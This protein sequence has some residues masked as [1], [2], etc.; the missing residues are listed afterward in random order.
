MNF[1]SFRFKYTPL[2]IMWVFYFLFVLVRYFILKGDIS[3]SYSYYLELEP[4]LGLF[5]SL[6]SFS[7]ILIIFTLGYVLF[8]KVTK[9]NFNLECYVLKNQNEDDIK[10][11]IYLFF[12]IQIGILFYRYFIFGES[13]TS[14]R[15]AFLTYLFF[16]DWFIPLALVIPFIIISNNISRL[17][18]ILFVLIYVFIILASGMKSA[19]IYVIYM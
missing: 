13:V 8:F 15:P 5:P 2:I 10:K 16:L 17:I 9:L 18:K 1:N 12:F 6:I 3:E 4:S 14:G 11:L 7:I 19:L